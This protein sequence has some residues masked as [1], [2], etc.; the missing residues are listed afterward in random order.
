MVVEGEFGKL[1]LE[2]AR[3]NGLFDTPYWNPGETDTV[4]YINASYGSD[5]FTVVASGNIAGVC[6][7]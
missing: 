7:F 3:E 6:P 4:R 1:Q 2:I 5:T